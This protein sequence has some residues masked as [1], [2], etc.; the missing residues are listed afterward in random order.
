MELRN[1]DIPSMDNYYNSTYWENNKNKDIIKKTKLSNL[2]TSDMFNNYTSID[3]SFNSNIKN[4]KSRK[5]A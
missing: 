5:I 4:R 3:N 2:S 1:N